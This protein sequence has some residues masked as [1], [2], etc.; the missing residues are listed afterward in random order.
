M[1]T[2]PRRKKCRAESCR[3]WFTPWSTMQKAC[4]PIC[5]IEVAEQDKRKARKKDTKRRRE[6]LK[7]RSQWTKEAQQAFNA[8]IRERDR[9]KP[10]ISCGVHI[11]DHR[12]GGG[13]DCGHYRSTGANPELRFCEANAHKQCKKC[14]QYLSGNVVN[15]RIG[16]ERRIGPE[17]LAW[18]EGPHPPKKYTIGE[19]K[20][21]R[22]HYRRKTR[23]KANA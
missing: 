3:Q 11:V 8:F 13:W 9:T 15:F 2:K 21:I 20:E 10:C 12:H 19:L 5:A 17:K 16:L 7:T 23:E 6:K 4:S 1:I 14:N 22:D 18:L